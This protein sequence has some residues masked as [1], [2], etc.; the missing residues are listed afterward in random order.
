MR[1]L[2]LA[3]SLLLASASS[4][5]GQEAGG[6]ELFTA[7]EDTSEEWRKAPFAIRPGDLLRLEARWNL[8][9]PDLFT[10]WVDG[11][12][13]GFYG[14]PPQ[15]FLDG[16]EVDVAFFGWQNLNMLP[17]SME[18]SS[19]LQSGFRPG[20]R[21]GTRIA[22]G[23]LD[24]RSARADSGW[25]A[26]AG[27]YL[28]NESG[29]PGPWVYDSSR[30]TPN[31]DRW[32]PDGSA[33]ISYAGGGWYL[34]ATGVLREH[35]PTDVASMRRLNNQRYIPET[36]TF[37][38]IK[39]SA[40]GT[41]L[42]SGYRD[43]RWSMRT[44]FLYSR[45]A[46]F[47][48]LQPFGRE[49]PADNRYG[50]FGAEVVRRTGR[51]ELSGRYIHDRKT[52]AYR[53]NINDYDLDWSAVTHKLAVSPA[54]RGNGLQ[55]KPGVIVRRIRPSGRG[56]EGDAVTAATLSLEGTIAA[57]KQADIYFHGTADREGGKK[58]HSVSLGSRFRLFSFLAADVRLYHEELL[59]RRQNAF[60]WWSG[61]GWRFPAG[62]PVFQPGDRKYLN[63]SLDGIEL[64]H[65][66]R[67][68]KKVQVE[69]GHRWIRHSHL[70]I[71]WQ[72]VLPEESYDVRPGHFGITGQQGS[73][74]TNRFSLSHRESAWSQDLTLVVH[75]TTG[76]YARYRDYF[77]Q[78]PSTR[79]QYA[80]RWQVAP[81]TLLSLQL[82]YRSESHWREYEEVEGREYRSL[83][84]FY[85]RQ[86]G[87][88]AA[89]VPGWA[90]LGLSARKWFW[91]RRLSLQLS[92]E[93][94]LDTEIRM[95][96]IGAEKSTVLHVRA[97]IHLE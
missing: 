96:P 84:P 32:G 53:T 11:G 63:S 3:I 88:I 34:N 90:D 40:G 97:A 86:T 44:R 23:Y 76:G 21:N 20:V 57:G 73:R 43:E 54:W 16:M 89:R 2:A 41:L 10:G 35:Q 50:Q 81:A 58:S 66:Y 19:G 42:E 60:A 80:F 38:P 33:R 64:E 56:L 91:D 29:D 65:R 72:R 78:V 77:A 68:S 52:A 4:L 55:L 31:V 25:R 74:M 61:R 15:V 79:I 1:M 37:H 18:A 22:S 24:F 5:L 83:V 13:Y 14:P 70:N 94:V 82:R 8:A 47:L 69:I 59:F 45:S 71:P 27:A 95:H 93:N 30:V 46:D 92:L 67:I 12:L 62:N 26:W 36:A 6:G 49:V 17:L 85:P 51:W 28:G 7:A 87:T 39:I 48:F 75:R 9:S